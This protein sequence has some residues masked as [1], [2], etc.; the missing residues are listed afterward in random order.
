MKLKLLSETST[1]FEEDNVEWDLTRFF[2]EARG[3]VVREQEKLE[4]AEETRKERLA[5][6]EAV[7]GAR[8]SG[9]DSKGEHVWSRSLVFTPSGALKVIG[10][11][12]EKVRFLAPLSLT[13]T[14]AF[15]LLPTC[16]SPS[17]SRSTTAPF[18]LYS[19]SLHDRP[20]ITEQRPHPPLLPPRRWSCRIR[21]LPFRNLPRR[22]RAPSTSSVWR[23]MESLHRWQCA[24][25]DQE[26][27]LV[28]RSSLQVPR[29]RSRFPHSSTVS[30]TFLH[31]CA[32]YVY[33]L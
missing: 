27:I 31:G 30:S 33:R 19:P 11:R 25:Y 12:L 1:A 32:P 6:G 14:D 17:P 20:S 28:R 21:L 2:E 29:V 23:S 3:K 5:A 15:L 24:T 4:L 22:R 8:I 7:K 16:H 9:P 18:T 26:G 13:S 10:R